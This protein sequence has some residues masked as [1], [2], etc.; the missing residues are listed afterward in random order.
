[1]N[2]STKL[3]KMNKETLSKLDAEIRILRLKINQLDTEK[4]AL[5]FQKNSKYP[6]KYYKEKEGTDLCYVSR[7]LDGGDLYGIDVTVYDDKEVGISECQLHFVDEMIEITKDEFIETTL[8]L[9]K[10]YLNELI[11]EQSHGQGN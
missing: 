4:T 3:N 1:M 7:I 9:T 2:L 8:D 11:K 6:S 10:V 5:L